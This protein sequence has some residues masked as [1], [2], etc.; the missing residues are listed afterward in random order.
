MGESRDLNPD[1]GRLR[2]FFW[3][4]YRYELKKLLPMLLIFFLITF[5]YNVLRTM[6][7]ALVVNGRSSGAEVIPF[8]KVWFMFPGTVLFTIL[9]TRLANRYSR[10]AVFYCMISAFL[11][12][13]A[14]FT[15]ILYPNREFLHPNDF[16]DKLETILPS[17]LN[18]L[19]AAIRNWTCTL[20]YVMSEIWGN[21][22]LSLLMWGFVNQVTRLGEAKRF[23]ALFGVGINSSG[24]IAGWLSMQMN[25]GDFNPSLPFGNTAWEQ[26]MILLIGTVLVVGVMIMLLFGYLNRCVLT[27]PRYY[28]PSDAKQE[29]KVRGN[30]SMRDSIK[31][32][33]KSRYL[34]YLAVIVLTYNIVINLVEVVWKHELS[35]LYPRKEDFAY[36]MSKITMIMGFFATFTSMFIAGNSVRRFGWSFTALLTPVIL[37]V[38]S[39]LFFGAYYGK[40][41]AP[42]LLASLTGMQPLAVVVFLGSAQN[43]LSR[44]AKY[45]VFDETREM[46]LIP[47]SPDCKIKGKAVIDGVCSRLGKAMGSLTLQS[48]YCVFGPISACMPYI[49]TLLGATISVWL[50]ITRMLGRQFNALITEQS[51]KV[52]LADVADEVDQAEDVEL[53]EQPA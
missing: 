27:D 10:E 33:M 46:A 15:F 28:D 7:D 16:A 45:T 35:E 24:I 6:K 49:T 20:F 47:L 18:G 5:N 52:N 3:P 53:A 4:I 36:Y 38:T 34:I 37:L 8:I 50:V 1:F 30:V 41:Y 14:A 12:F 25:F 17:G 19:I 13:F 2:S 43:I 11:I 23:Y 44:S 48:L 51:S 40:E 32:L 9:F 21:I 26:T 42:D 39:I 29:K 31:Y 22:V